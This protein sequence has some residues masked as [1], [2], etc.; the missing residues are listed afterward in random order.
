M[1]RE[2]C[3]YHKEHDDDLP[4]FHVC[5]YKRSLMKPNDNSGCELCRLWDAYIPKNASAAEKEK[6]KYWQSL[7]TNEQPDYD[8]Y[9]N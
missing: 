5:E 7:P 3:E 4:E 8:E 9:F 1:I 6:A 2:D